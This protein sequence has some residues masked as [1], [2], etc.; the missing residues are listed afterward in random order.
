MRLA[1]RLSAGSAEL[2]ARTRLKYRTEG[3]KLV[4]RID[5]AENPPVG[6]AVEQDLA[7]LAKALGAA[8]H[9]IRTSA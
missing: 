8:D 9:A 7:A 3:G 2:L 1:Y 6:G 5:G 4:L